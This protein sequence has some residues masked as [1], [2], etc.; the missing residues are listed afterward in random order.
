MF[1][2]PVLLFRFFLFW[3]SIGES[4]SLP[5]NRVYHILWNVSLVLCGGQK[6]RQREVAKRNMNT[7]TFIRQRHQPWFSRSSHKPSNRI[8]TRMSDED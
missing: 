5:P 2:S 1:H 6:S 8:Y 4:I 7:T 3:G